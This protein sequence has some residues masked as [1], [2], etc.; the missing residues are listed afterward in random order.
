MI[1]IKDIIYNMMNK[2]ILITYLIR[3]L[4]KKRSIKNDQNFSLSSTAEYNYSP[5][6]FNNF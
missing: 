3:S 5:P 1:L 2:V 4:L 6:G